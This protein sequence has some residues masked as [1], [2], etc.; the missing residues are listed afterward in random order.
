M[1]GTN[2]VVFKRISMD[3]TVYNLEQMIKICRNKL[4]FPVLTTIIPRNDKRWQKVFFRDRIFELNDKIRELAA[5]VKVSFIDMFEIFYTWP[6]SDGGWTSL[7]SNDHVHPSIK[8]Y[9]VMTDSWFE[10]IKRFPFS[11]KNI[12]ATRLLEQID[13][14]HQQGNKISWNH[15]PKLYDYTDFRAYKIYRSK[16][17]DNPKEF[18]LIKTVT[19]EHNDAHITGSIGFPGLNRFGEYYLDLDIDPPTRYKYALRL[20]RKDGVVGPSSRIAKD[21]AQGGTEH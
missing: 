17:G 7:L 21:N 16:I 2:D 1:E 19:L 18:T 9:E 11:P 14:A 15:S 20:I 12:K 13:D 4:V 10:E 6:E 8:G 5:R 3:T